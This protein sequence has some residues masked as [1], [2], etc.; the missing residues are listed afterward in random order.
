[1]L[2]RGNMQANLT[3][4]SEVRSISAANSYNHVYHDGDYKRI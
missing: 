3:G 2:W 4:S 1:M